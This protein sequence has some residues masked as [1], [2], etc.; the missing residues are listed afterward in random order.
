MDYLLCLYVAFAL[1]QGI[2]AQKLKEES[3]NRFDPIIPE[4]HICYLDHFDPFFE[5]KTVPD[6]IN[7][8]LYDRWGTQIGA[9]IDPLF[10]LG[11]ALFEEEQHRSNH[12][13][14]WYF[15]VEAWIDGK[16]YSQDGVTTFLG[17]YCSG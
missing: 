15:Y 3:D 17:W 8:S 12:P 6:S 10:L 4:N 7:F 1:D 5:W 11:E 13:D 14:H 9:S 16:K 2:A